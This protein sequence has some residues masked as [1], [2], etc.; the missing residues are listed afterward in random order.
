[1][2]RSTKKYIR[3]YLRWLL[4]GE[5]K[6]MPFKMNRTYV[7]RSRKSKKKMQRIELFQVQG[8]RRKVDTITNVSSYDLRVLINCNNDYKLILTRILEKLVCICL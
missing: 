7:I 6:G 8:N 1:M 4:W 3:G 2:E 5:N